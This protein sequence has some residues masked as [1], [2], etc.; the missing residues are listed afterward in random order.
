MRRVFHVLAALFLA[1]ACLA[2]APVRAAEVVDRIVAVVNG[3]IVTLFELNER[4]KPVL[5]QFKGRQISDADKQAILKLKR[6][7][8]QKLIDDILLEQEVEKLKVTVSDVEVENQLQEFKNQH[9]LTEENLVAQLKLEKMSRNEFADKMRRDILRQRLL[10][11]MVR[12]KVVVTS[13][14]VQ[15]Y[16]DQHKADFAKD[17]SVRLALILLPPGQQAEPLRERIAKG[18]MS[19]AEA[20]DAFS[21]GPGAGQ[22]GDV[23]VL[24]WKSLAP[25]WR[26]ALN[27]VPE[28]GISDPFVINGR[29]ALL[30]P[31]SLQSGEVQGLGAI[32]NDIR[33]KIYNEKLE[34]RFNEY[35]DQLRANAVIDVRM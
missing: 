29:E 13:E 31:R 34:A 16:Y 7:L 28:G 9:N 14:D 32:E 10:G 19:F 2:P 26:Q 12:R 25:E 3:K 33:A 18:E 17:R 24:E 35:M 22:G 27:G 11:V 20:A 5:D 23:G 6:E 4:L 30:S 21:Q 15:R 8:L 1:L